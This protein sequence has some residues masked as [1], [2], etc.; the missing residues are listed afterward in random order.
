MPRLQHKLKFFNTDINER[1]DDTKFR[2]QHGE[3]GFTLEDEYD[4]QQCDPAYGEN[5]PTTEEYGEA[6]DGTPLAD[7]EDLI[8]DRYNKYTGAK[9][10][11]DEKLNNDNN[12][13]NEIRRA[14]D[15]YEAPIGQAYRKP[16]LDTREFEVDLEN[17]D[18][19]KKMENQIYA[20]L[21]SQLDDEDRDILQ[22]KGIIDHNKD[23]SALTK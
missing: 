18:T 2:I 3:G 14:T 8:D 20:N 4:L 1:I 15:E 19:D 13:A 10:I 16:M 5:D 9:L 7:A 11:I 21:Y 23:G 12:L 6:N 17:G 22:F